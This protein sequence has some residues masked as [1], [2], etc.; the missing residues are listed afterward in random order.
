M[1][2]IAELNVLLRT[3]IDLPDGLK[4]ATEEFREGWNFVRSGD[5]RR[6]E[7]RIQTR[8][9]NFIKIAD[10]EL[11]SG[12]G[13]TSQAAIASALKLALR[14]VSTYFNA[15]EVEHIEL[16]QYPWFFLA[17]VRVYPYRIQQGAVLPAADEAV[18]IPMVAQPRRL[19]PQSVELFPHFGSA[20]PMLKEML[21]SARS[22]E[23]R[24]Q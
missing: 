19:P 24:A 8:G 20:M 10:G 9:W 6:L 22:S 5:A 16:T 14:R 12:V 3:P 23:A 1:R 21:V 11:R 2:T 18:S 13:E 4:L 17:R 15:V 7:K